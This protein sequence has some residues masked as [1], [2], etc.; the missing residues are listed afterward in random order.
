M[1]PIL[2]TLFFLLLPL[3]S[4][5]ASE[6]DSLTAQGNLLYDNHHYEAAIPPFKTAIGLYLRAGQ[7]MQAAVARHQ[8]SFALLAAGNF[9]EAIPYL[10]ENRQF[11][12]AEG[13]LQD[14][15]NYLSYIANAWQQQGNNQ[16]AL[17]YLQQA[18]DLA[19]EPEQQARFDGSLLRLYQDTDQ[20]E[21]AQ[22]LVTAAYCHHTRAHYDQHLRPWA[23]PFQLS[24]GHCNDAPWLPEVTAGL[25]VLALLWRWPVN[26]SLLLLS[27]TLAMLAGEALLRWGVGSVPVRHFLFAPNSSSRFVPAAGIMPGVDYR[28]SHF[29]I[30]DIGLRGEPLPREAGVIKGLAIGGSTTECLFLDDADVWTRQ[31]Q[32]QLSRRRRVW[33]GNSGKSGLNSFGHL[34]QV[35]A[36]LREIKP[37]WLLVMA[38]INDLNLCISGGLAAIRDN[39]RLAAEPGYP[40]SYRRHVFAQIDWSDLGLWQWQRLWRR[41]AL[42]DRAVQRNPAGP[43]VV[44]DAAGL[45]YQEQ[46]QRRQQA[47]MVDTEPDIGQCLEPFRDNLSRMAQM[48]KTAG[49]PLVLMTQGALYKADMPAAEEALLWFGSVDHNF[50]GSQPATHYYSARVMARLLARYNDVTLS[51]C[52]SAQIP[53]FDTDQQL[54]KDVTTYYDDVHFNIHG[55]YMLGEKL[56]AF[57]ETAHVIAGEPAASAP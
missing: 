37:H 23:E 14:A 44:Q 46:R 15:A 26:G 33:V 18:R 3:T 41:I 28:E 48:A 53:C 25:L 30:N 8:L 16:Q 2:C 12:L 32:S 21:A 11:H 24:P 55:A 10:E 45:F 43:Y 56:A 36:H 9:A 34:V 54:P 31:L 5:A 42:G 40:A 7:P 35:E 6:A 22:A 39:A 1:L 51:L 52:R 49:V 47:I 50:F 20:P 27:L 38:G 4:V 57:L 17:A 13:R 19:L 29:S